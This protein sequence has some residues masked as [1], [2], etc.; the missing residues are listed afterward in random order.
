MDVFL[1]AIISFLGV[2]L[3]AV[4]SEFLRR[5]N[6]IESFANPV[7]EKRLSAYHE[8]FKKVQEANQVADEVITNSSYSQQERT[9]LVSGEILEIARFCDD[10]AFFIDTDL[11]AHCT[12]LLMGVEDIYV[13]EGVTTK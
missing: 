1:G 9:E 7:F 4:L 2:T 10:N 11:G 6:R 12:A 5:R 13:S 8:L 3:G